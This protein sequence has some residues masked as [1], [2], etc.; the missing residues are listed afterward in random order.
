MTKSSKR[1]HLRPEI[2]NALNCIEIS[3]AFLLTL[4]GFAR[5]LLFVIGVD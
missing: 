4:Y 5:V 1:R 2:R 3:A